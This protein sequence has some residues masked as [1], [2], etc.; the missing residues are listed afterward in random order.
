MNAFPKCLLKLFAATHCADC[1]PQPRDV[2]YFLRPLCADSQRCLSIAHSVL[3]HVS[4]GPFALFVS[5]VSNRKSLQCFCAQQS[6]S[7]S[8]TRRLF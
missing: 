8:P 1:V 6:H 2:R 5:V 7:T 3:G 4:A